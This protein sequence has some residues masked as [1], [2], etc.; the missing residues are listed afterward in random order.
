[1]SPI[2]GFKVEKIMLKNNDP[3]IF[4]FEYIKVL[5]RNIWTYTYD[6]SIL[7]SILF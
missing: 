1:M 2:K 4:R 3:Q 6:I 7:F 5:Y